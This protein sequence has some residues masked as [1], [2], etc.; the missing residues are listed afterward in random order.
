MSRWTARRRSIGRFISF[1]GTPD[2]FLITAGDMRVLPKI[3][4]AASRFEARPSA[5]EMAA[6]VVEFDIQPIF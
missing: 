6:D 4:D 2:I 5:V 3:L 1:W